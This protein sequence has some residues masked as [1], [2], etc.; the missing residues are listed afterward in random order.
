AGLAIFTLASLFCAIA[1]AAGLLILGRVI[2]GVGGAWI[3]ATAPALVTDAFP[4]NELGRALGI[5]AMVIGA[6][7]MLGPILGGLLTGI[8]W[9]SGVWVN[10]PVGTRAGLR[11]L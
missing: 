9:G 6:G 8:G 2:Q 10:V 11:G 1:P 3:M 4:R 7:L 5:T